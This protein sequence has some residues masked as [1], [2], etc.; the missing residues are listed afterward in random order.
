MAINYKIILLIVFIFINF[1]VLIAGQYT[2]SPAEG[3]VRINSGSTSGY[4]QE[5]YL[6]AG[7]SSSAQSEII[8]FPAGVGSDHKVMKRWADGND[9]F[10]YSIPVD[11]SLSAPLYISMW[12]KGE[13]KLTETENS[14]VLLDTG[15]S[16][17]GSL[18]AREF[19]LTDPSIW[20]DG[21]ITLKFEDADPSDGWGPNVYWIEVGKT[22][23]WRERIKRIQWDTSGIIWQVGYYDGYFHEFQ[24]STSNIT[25]SSDATD[26]V[27]PTI[28]SACPTPCTND[29]KN[30]KSD[31]SLVVTWNQTKQAGKKYYFLLGIIGG[32]TDVT[33]DM[34]NNGSIDYTRSSSSGRIRIHDLDVTSH[35]S[36]G[37]NLAKVNVPTSGKVDFMTLV[38]IT[39]GHIID[40]NLKISFQGNEMAENW[41]RLGNTT[42]FFNNEIMFDK[43]TGFIDA[44]PP[45]GLFGNQFWVSDVGPVAVE[46]ARWG[47]YD[48]AKQSTIFKDDVAAYYDETV[49]N[50][51]DNGAASLIFAAMAYLMKSDN[52]TGAFTTDNWPGLKKGLDAFAT[53]VTASPY[54]L[55]LGNAVETTSISY[56]VYNNSLAHIALKAGAEV[57]DALGYTV[58]KNS[59]NAAALS[60]KDKMKQHLLLTSNVTWKNQTI[61]AG[62]FRY[63]IDA[64]G[65]DVA[66]GRNRLDNNAY[67]NAP[68]A[69]WFGVG[70]HEEN[71]YGLR[72]DA[73]PDWRNAVNAMLDYHSANFWTNWSDYGHNRGFGTSYGVMSERGGW[74]VSAMILSDRMGMLEKNLHHIVYNSSDLNFSNDNVGVSELSPWAIVREIDADD[75]GITGAAIGNGGPNEDM[76]LIEYILVL[77]NFRLMAGID[78]SMYAT[79]NLTIIPRIPESWSGVKVKDWPFIYKSGGNY[80]KSNLTYDYVRD[81]LSA[82]MTVS[83][84]NSITADVRVGPFKLDSVVNSVQVDSVATNYTV[85]DNGGFRW[86][87]VTTS[88]GTTNKVISASVTPPGEQAYISTGTFSG[89]TSN[90]GTWTYPANNAEVVATGDSWLSS[91]TMPG[92]ITIESEVKLISG[93]AVGI[94]V[95]SDGTGNS[96]Y[97]LILDSA[98]GLFKLAKR[99]YSV[100]ASKPV[101]TKMNRSYTIKLRAMGSTLEGYLDGVKVLSAT[102]S[103]YTSG[104]TALFGYMST[105]QFDNVHIFGGG[106]STNL[107]GT[108]TAINTTATNTDN[109]LKLVSTGDGFYMN[110]QIGTDFTYEADIA[111]NTTNPSAGALVFRANATPSTGSYVVTLSSEGANGIVKLFKFPYVSLVEYNLPSALQKDQK[112]HVKVVTSG[113]NIKVYFD[114]STNPVIDHNDST[115]TTGRF[116]LNSWSGT[117]TFQNVNKN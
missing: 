25:T 108:W 33:V 111:V 95:R 4:L 2:D 83:A 85:Q 79:N 82:S 86:I 101:K 24:G 32:T 5:Q 97:D 44:S 11:S 20:A 3:Q 37:N 30:L 35:I 48:M 104:K 18:T 91:G 52:Y 93:N 116:G 62:T 15:N 17:A 112:Y 10:S 55:I 43:S 80:S 34:G 77:K 63:G 59:W 12:T 73:I 105:A 68:Q 7:S 27:L 9:S 41:T 70:S 98:D 22:T 31:G 74:P 13:V 88:I 94:S 72:G 50:R 46:L 99:P 51:A 100:L 102:D 23:P 38:E 6:V 69:G 53:K 115:Y 49:F 61:P 92:D 16:G 56:G 42:M 110:D 114:N 66:G 57:A 19:S 90:A 109:G 47:Y 60:I 29:I 84:N 78:D 54:D 113:S 1:K 89:W 87:W 45:N 36:N 14:I 64:A 8:A 39:D 58:E 21:N 103:S 65:N 81:P 117:A 26:N 106:F 71:F 75:D 96:G 107:G 28:N 67:Y 40:D 76:N